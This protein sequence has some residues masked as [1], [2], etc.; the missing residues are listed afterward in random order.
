MN[1]NQERHLSRTISHALRHAPHLY[2][3]ELD[4]EGWTPITHLI[5]GLHAHRRAWRVVDLALIEEIVAR[6]SKGR[7]EIDLPH[8]RIRAL[9]GHSTTTRLKK[10]LATPPPLLYHGTSPEIARLI[11]TE[12]LKSMARQ[13][14]HHAV[15]RATAL[16]VGHRKD[17]APVLLHVHAKKAHAHG[18][19]FYEGNALIWLSDAVPPE[20]I[21]SPESTVNPGQE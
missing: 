16:E 8:D 4:E 15:D 19:K 3:L 9:Y 2:E 10:T 5:E 7:Y 14:V 20:F 17:E 18:V 13:Y 11:L 6:D 21:T 1:R 12:G